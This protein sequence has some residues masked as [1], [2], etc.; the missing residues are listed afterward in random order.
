VHVSV[1]RLLG[2]REV[3]DLAFRG[4]LPLSRDRGSEQD[5]ETEQDETARHRRILY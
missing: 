1:R 4:G 2:D 3:Q 5:N